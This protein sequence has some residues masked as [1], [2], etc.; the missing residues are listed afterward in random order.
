MQTSEKKFLTERLPLA[1]F[2]HATGRLQFITCEAVG[3]NK[4]VL[5]SQT[6]MEKAIMRSLNSR[7]AQSVPL[8][9]SLP[10]KIPSSKDDGYPKSKIGI[11]HAQ[12][13]R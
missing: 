12:Y 6:Q 11:Y 7:K 9:P 3:T 1:I 10:V 4:F 8:L 5:R 2:L 13:I